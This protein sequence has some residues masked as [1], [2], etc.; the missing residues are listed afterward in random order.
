MS[1]CFKTLFVLW[2]PEICFYLH[3]TPRMFDLMIARSGLNIGH[4][5]LKC[6]S[7]G[8]ISLKL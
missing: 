8:L 6:R 7:L 3:E 5:G 4:V 1:N 2:R